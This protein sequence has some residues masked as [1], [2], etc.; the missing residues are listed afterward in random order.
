[1]HG[2]GIDKDAASKFEFDTL[3]KE[4]VRLLQAFSGELWTD[5]NTHDP[6]VTL[7]ESCCF[8]LTDLI[9]RADADIAD[10]ICEQDGTIDFRSLSLYEPDEVF[11]A[12][13]A[14]A[15]DFRAV[16]LDQCPEV[17]NVWLLTDNK[18]D[19]CSGLFHIKISIAGQESH[20][21]HPDQEKIIANVRQV[22]YRN[23]NLGEDVSTISI[24]ARD[25]CVLGCDVELLPEVRPSVVL[26]EIYFYCAHFL[27]DAPEYSS[28]EDEIRNGGAYE[29]V[30]DGPLFEYVVPKKN[31]FK[32][33]TSG[34]IAISQLFGVIKKI[35]G[36][37]HIKRLSVLKGGIVYDE[38]I[39]LNAYE[40]VLTLIVPDSE[41]DIQVRLFREGKLLP[42][43]L[44]EM[45]ARYNELRAR[46]RSL[47]KAKQNFHHLMTKPTGHYLALND[48]SSMQNELP[49]IYGTNQHGVPRS[50]DE[51]VKASA[52]QLKSYMLFFEQIMA[53]YLAN[54]SKIK[55]L[56]ST[57]SVEHSYFTQ[58]LSN[59]EIRDLDKIYP[60]NALDVLQDTLTYCDNFLDRRNRVLDY[61]LAMHG[62]SYIDQ[63]I[64]YFDC[65]AS[66]ANSQG[67]LIDQKLALLKLIVSMNKD[68]AGAFR[69]DKEDTAEDNVA[70]LQRRIAIYL[71]LRAVS[72]FGNLSQHLTEIGVRAI[73]RFSEADDCVL[74]TSLLSDN[75]VK[76]K[77]VQ[78]V[79]LLSNFDIQLNNSEILST[80]NLVRCSSFDED[81]LNAGVRIE[82]FRIV[83]LGKNREYKLLC[84][85]PRIKKYFDLT[86]S[87][88]IDFLVE[89]ANGLRYLLIDLNRNSEGLF[90]VEHVLL[91]PSN[92]HTPEIDLSFF[93]MQ[94]TVVLPAWT[95]RFA[96]NRFQQLVEE[97]I[98]R[99][100]PAHLYTHVLWLEYEDLLTFEALYHGWRNACRE[101]GLHRKDSQRCAAEL[102]QFLNDRLNLHATC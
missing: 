17:E 94:L 56:Y 60:D 82:Y 14:S 83:C 8:A 32:K 2:Q 77:E 84:Y 34:S 42:F 76:D 49:A 95:A 57:L 31:Q 63:V 12:R 35:Y 74:N 72:Y 7:L 99:C 96:D 90:L 40:S 22:F 70:V 25:S 100:A 64:H 47:R 78:R 66:S 50:A 9:N 98:R 43:S 54:L 4:G 92:N 39:P 21:L 71:G 29:G 20:L 46:F 91:R 79:P 65:Y 58:A 36:V 26:A 28:Y 97:I 6:G 11:T 102:A 18:H 81:L 38:V 1:M 59:K 13:P 73:K 93:N 55:Q 15:D 10:L 87:D 30:F 45:Q 80:L 48:Y 27:S 61:L 53:N 62:E 37:D 23:R 3:K 52:I 33:E 51:Q 68:R 85:L 75:F 86:A 67:D 16:I 19:I 5:F 88:N 101:L 69:Y 24:L 44:V 89:L 41:D